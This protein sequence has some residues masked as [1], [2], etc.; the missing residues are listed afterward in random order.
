MKS[1]P[2]GRAPLS[3]REAIICAAVSGWAGDGMTPWP[4]PQTADTIFAWARSFRNNLSED[5]VSAAF[6]VLVQEGLFH[7]IL[8][9][10][11]KDPVFFCPYESKFLEEL[12]NCQ[13][14]HALGFFIAEAKDYWDFLLAELTKFGPAA[15]FW[16]L[17]QGQGSQGPSGSPEGPCLGPSCAWFTEGNSKC[18]WDLTFANVPRDGWPD[19]RFLHALNIDT[20]SDRHKDLMLSA[21]E[22]LRRAAPYLPWPS[23]KQLRWIFR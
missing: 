21:I 20:E 17:C 10:I 16:G 4:S 11:F 19:L 2:Q 6:K 15:I 5:D 1:T 13:Q 23:E 7:E 9:P 18:N 12:I 8:Y 3:A 22:H 14:E